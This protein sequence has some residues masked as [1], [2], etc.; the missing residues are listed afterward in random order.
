MKLISKLVICLAMILGATS[1]SFASSPAKDPIFSSFTSAFDL[2]TNPKTI[3]VPVPQNI[4][5]WFSE[6]GIDGTQIDSSKATPEVKRSIE[7]L[8]TARGTTTNTYT[9]QVNL[10][11]LER[12]VAPA[13]HAALV[14]QNATVAKMHIGARVWTLAESNQ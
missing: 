12:L 8:L 10:D 9:E 2:S 3:E 5:D 1:M 7:S 6:N 14:D 4:R 11:A 13:L